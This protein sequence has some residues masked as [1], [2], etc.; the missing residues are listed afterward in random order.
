MA[1][2][3]PPGGPPRLQH[4]LMV[5]LGPARRPNSLQWQNKNRYVHYCLSTR[6]STSIGQK[7]PQDHEEKLVSF[8]RYVIQLSFVTCVQ[9]G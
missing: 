6:A 9:H 3:P 2:G 1:A 7:L 5:A 8:Q 4:R